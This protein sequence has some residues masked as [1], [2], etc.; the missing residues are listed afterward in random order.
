MGI[1][2]NAFKIPGKT[3]IS[4]Q[5]KDF[6][7]KACA[8]IKRRNLSHLAAMAVDATLPLH[9]LTSQAVIFGMP[10]LNMIFSKEDIQRLA[11]LLQN[12]SAFDFFKENI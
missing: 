3:P 7:L 9:N 10:F 8:L 5:D 11:D 2:K 6:I 4:Q 1:W 12:P